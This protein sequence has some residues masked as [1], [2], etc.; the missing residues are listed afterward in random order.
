M[1]TEQF[2]NNLIINK[3]DTAETYE[4]MKTAGLVSDE[5]I[6][7]IE[8]PVANYIKE[9]NKGAAQKFWRGTKEEFDA[10]AEKAEDTMYIVTDEEEINAATYMAKSVYDPQGKNTDVFAY[11]DRAIENAFASIARAEEVG[12]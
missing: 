5:E 2:L 10:I 12:F 7:L 8:N 9:V 4:T 1:P 11:V 6:Y 3:V